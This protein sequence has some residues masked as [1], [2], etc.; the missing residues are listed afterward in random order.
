MQLAYLMHFA[1]KEIIDNTVLSDLVS[2]LDIPDEPVREG[3][4]L[5]LAGIGSR[6]KVAVPKLQTILREIDCGRTRPEFAQT[7]RESLTGIGAK[8]AVAECRSQSR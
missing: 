1:P 6:A 7:I 3:V 5:S 8:P 2:L 4:A